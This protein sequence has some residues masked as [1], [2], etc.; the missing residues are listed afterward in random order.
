[1]M[2]TQRFRF[3]EASLITLTFPEINQ[4]ASQNRQS[5]AWAAS[6]ENDAINFLDGLKRVYCEHCGKFNFW[7]ADMCECLDV[8]EEQ[9]EGGI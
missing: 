4:I 5:A 3:K 6:H 1:M 8:T 9:I 7:P 2:K